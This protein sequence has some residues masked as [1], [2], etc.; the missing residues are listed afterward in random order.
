METLCF[1]ER[2]P[3]DPRVFAQCLEFLMN[4]YADK[5]DSTQPRIESDHVKVTKL[6]DLYVKFFMH[7]NST[8]FD[9]VC[10]RTFQYIYKMCNLPNLI[11]E[12]IILDIWERLSKI[13]EQLANV[14]VT[15]DSPVVPLSQAP[16]IPGTF[17]STTIASPIVTL[18]VTLAARFIFMIGYI[19]MKELIYLD[20]D[21]YCNLKVRQELANAKKHKNKSNI[22]EASRATSQNFSA[23]AAKR[24]SMMPPAEDEE[25][26]DLIGQTADDAFAEQINGICETELLTHKDSIFRKFIPMI[27]EVLKFPTQFKYPELQSAALLS[28]IHL[29]SVSSQFCDKNIPFL[30]NV[31]QHAQNVDIKCNIIIGMSDFT[32][33]FPNVI[34][35]W[36]GQLY[37]TLHDE[38]RDLRLTSVRILSHLISHEMI[39]VKVQISDLALCL[40]DHD[41]EIRKTTEVFFKEIANKSNILYNALPDIISRLSDPDLSLEEGKYHKIMKYIIGLIKKDRQVESLVEKL[42]FRFRITTQERQWRDIAFCLSLLNYTEKTIK[43]LIE[44]IGF[45]KDKVRAQEVFDY[46]KSIITN[47]SKLAKPELRVSDSTD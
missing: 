38:D 28:L 23:T 10:S 22:S 14:K 9:D 13:S 27:L 36:S 21:V 11:S 35:P 29:M 7:E 43:K 40:E 46:F 19:A 3:K 45:F 32:F 41:E 15:D 12:R 20:I 30:I 37:S 47:T 16:F 17:S 18:P 1:E 24:K 33:R 5:D 2:G 25:L 26:E 39:L 42:C 34:E 6:V 4:T 8:D 44:N 31:F